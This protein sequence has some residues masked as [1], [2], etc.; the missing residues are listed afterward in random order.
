VVRG[1]VRRDA[2]G[3]GDADLMRRVAAGDSAALGVLYDR[4]RARVHGFLRR[5]T[6]SDSDAEDVTHEVFLMLTRAAAKYDGR[7]CAAPFIMG[8]AAQ[9]MRQ[10]RRRVARWIRTVAAF[11]RTAQREV[12]VTPEDIA[13]GAEQL[14][15]FEEALSRLTEEK[16]LVFLL[17]EGEGMS[18]DEVSGVLGIPV[19]TVWTR[20]HYARADLGN[21]IERHA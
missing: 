20:L 7:S 2:G 12:R 1:P 16:R 9:L 11:G 6:G 19:N 8:V 18:G 15:R 13:T 10:R 14:R 21:A 5:A 3:Q 4:Y 17:V